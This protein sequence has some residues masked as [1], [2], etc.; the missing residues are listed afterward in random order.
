LA[1][2]ETLVAHRKLGQTY[3]ARAQQVKEA[4]IAKC[5]SAYQAYKAA[6]DAATIVRRSLGGGMRR[7]VNTNDPAYQ[8]ALKKY[9]AA[10]KEGD[11]AFDL[12]DK[13]QSEFKAV[14]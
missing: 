10:F 14:L 7:V 2:K 11:V 6:R 13:A 1:I 9:Q 12:F 4:V 5:E 3:Y 8:A